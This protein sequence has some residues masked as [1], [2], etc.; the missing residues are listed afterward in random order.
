MSTNPASDEQQAALT[1]LIEGEAEPH[2]DA[3]VAELLRSQPALR[4]QLR[5]QLQLDALLRLE[6]EPTAAAFVESVAARTRPPADDDASFLRRVH[7]ALPAAPGE[8]VNQRS[9]RWSWLS[10]RPLTAAAA[11]IVFGMFCTAVAFG[12]VMPRAV[13]TASRLFAL[14]DG[15]FEN[16]SVGAGFPKQTGAWSGDAAEVVV[17]VGVKAREGRR[18][19]RFVKAEGDANATD[20][21]ALACD[22]FQLVDLRPLRASLGAEG[23]SLLELS[24]SFLDARPTNTKPSVTFFCQLYLFKGDAANVH[25]AWPGNIPAAIASGSAEVTTL[26]GSSDAWRQLTAK[27]LVSAEADFAVV[28]ISARPNLRGP[29][30]P[31]LFVDDVKLT[32]KTQPTLPVRVVKR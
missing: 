30:P 25:Q 20:G 22:V 14:V 21:R 6:A 5:Q 15:S 7:A 23:N 24:A 32:L 8:A 4:A 31:Q 9:P 28:Q 19:L 12:F 11:G 1:R 2:D 17:A 13:A 29:M 10:W 26:G 3:L 18:M 27:S 16:D